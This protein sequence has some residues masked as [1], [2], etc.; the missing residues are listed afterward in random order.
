MVRKLQKLLVKMQSFETFHRITFDTD[1][2]PHF[3]V[4]KDVARDLGEEILLGGNIKILQGVIPQ[5]GEVDK[6]GVDRLI[7]Q[8]K[9]VHLG[10]GVE[11]HQGLSFLYETRY[12]LYRNT[13]TGSC[14]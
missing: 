11:M 6:D 5:I 4:N 10:Q 13:R 1:T 2:L 9:E 8:T 12:R 14:F 3:K 7:I